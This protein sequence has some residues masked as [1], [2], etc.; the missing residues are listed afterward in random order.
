[1]KNNKKS[2]A[3]LITVFVVAL[4]VGG[5]LI[6]FISTQNNSTDSLGGNDNTTNTQDE[7]SESMIGEH[8]QEEVLTAIIKSTPGLSDV[9][10]SDIIILSKNSPLKDWL[11][12]HFKVTRDNPDNVSLLS[13]VKNTASGGL[14]V[15]VPPNPARDLELIDN[16]DDLPV[17]VRDALVN[18][19]W[20]K[21]NEN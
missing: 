14:V 16:L 10:H 21:V 8:K 4:I 3:I 17:E 19:E 15:K 20:G 5:A 11:I 13:V 6:A 7:S 1:M 2:M 9:D 12:I 18:G